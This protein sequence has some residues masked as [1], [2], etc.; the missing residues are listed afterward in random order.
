MHLQEVGE[1]GMCVCVCC[2]VLVESLLPVYCPVGGFGVAG[3]VI[4]RAVSHATSVPVKPLTSFSVCF[5]PVSF[6][7][8]VNYLSVC[9]CLSQAL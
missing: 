8:P 7:Q 9:L 1:V 4:V 3:V 2:M 5:P 6:S